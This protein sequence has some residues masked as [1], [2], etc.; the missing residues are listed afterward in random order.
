MRIKWSIF[1]YPWGAGTCIGDI[2]GFRIFYVK[3]KFYVC[4]TAGIA[5][6]DYTP[7]FATPGGILRSVSE[8]IG[9]IAAFFCKYLEF[10]NR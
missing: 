1:T 9:P 7:G 10:K 3:S 4:V 6:G 5:E 2:S 8:N